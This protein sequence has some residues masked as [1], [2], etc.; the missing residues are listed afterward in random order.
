MRR[1]V[2]T[3]RNRGTSGRK[4]NRLKSTEKAN[5]KISLSSIKI[6]TPNSS[7]EMLHR[8]R[9]NKTTISSCKLFKIE[10]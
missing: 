1:S 2:K 8:I 7:T 4:D 3:P 6:L 5:L 9:I 10:N